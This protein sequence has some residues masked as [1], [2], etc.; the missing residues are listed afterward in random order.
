MNTPLDQAAIDYA[1]LNQSL[2][3]IK[4]DDDQVDRI[5]RLRIVAKHL[6]A[7]LTMQIRPSRERS[8]AITNLE[9]SVMWAVKAILLEDKTPI[10]EKVAEIVP[11]KGVIGSKAQG[12][13]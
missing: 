2:T 8:L 13:T 7:E 3:N 9:Q 5:E 6:G 10:Q 1:N 12:P 4:P 11:D